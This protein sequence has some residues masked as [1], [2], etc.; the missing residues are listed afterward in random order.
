MSRHSRSWFLLVAGAM[1]LTIIASGLSFPRG[2]GLRNSAAL[3]R[4]SHG[5]GLL[6]EAPWPKDLRHPRKRT[7]LPNDTPEVTE[8]GRALIHAGAK[9]KP[10][11]QEGGRFRITGNKVQFSSFDGTSPLEN[12]KTYVVSSSTLRVSEWLLVAL[13]SAAL[14]AWL[15]L[16]FRCGE[17]SFRLAGR[18]VDGA[19][20]TYRQLAIRGL[21]PGSSVP[22]LERFNKLLLPIPFFAGVAIGL[23]LCIL[24]G[25]LAARA[26]T[27]ADR[28]RFFYQIS[29]EGYV[30]PTLENLLQF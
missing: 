3:E 1:V 26:N 2:I 20:E 5:E 29:P 11:E 17:L 25:R 23:A 10:I 15:P 12:R 6:Y 13:W 21:L 4:I 8:N 18:F 19:S 9:R 27:F 7:L 16:A 14:L 22:L 30:Y 24:G 28:S